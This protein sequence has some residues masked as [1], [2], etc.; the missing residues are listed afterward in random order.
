MK[1]NSLDRQLIDTSTR[2]SLIKITGISLPRTQQE[3]ILVGFLC[4]NITTTTKLKPQKVYEVLM[5]PSPFAFWA[6]IDNILWALK[7][8]NNQTERHPQTS[9]TANS[10]KIPSLSF[11]GL[12]STS[13]NQIASELHFNFSFSFCRENPEVSQSLTDKFKWPLVCIYQSQYQRL[14]HRHLEPEI[15]ESSQLFVPLT[16]KQK[17][18]SPFLQ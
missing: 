8:L 3:G 15:L 10:I 12:P 4:S 17:L 6:K 7:G 2:L 9:S 14:L 16:R 13:T 1:K 5:M 11:Q 18:K